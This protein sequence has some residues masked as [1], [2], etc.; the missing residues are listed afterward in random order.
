MTRF[1]ELVLTP[2]FGKS[3]RMLEARTR[4]QCRKAL[5]CLREN[6]DHPGLNLKPI[7][8]SKLYWEARI[9]RSDRLVVRPE[10]DTAYIIEVV[11]GGNVVGEGTNDP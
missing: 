1:D 7:L 8:P 9:N 3:Y 5:R 6:P 2:R 11:K 10:G 4:N